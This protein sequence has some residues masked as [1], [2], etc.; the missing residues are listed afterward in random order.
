MHINQI[1]DIFTL[2]D[3]ICIKDLTNAAGQLSEFDKFKYTIDVPINRGIWI[4]LQSLA[5]Y[6]ASFS[7]INRIFHSK[8]DT[9]LL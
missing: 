6:F 3:N 4:T 7:H 9:Y 5:S 2:M 1:S 8:Y